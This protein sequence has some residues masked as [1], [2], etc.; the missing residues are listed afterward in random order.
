MEDIVSMNFSGYSVFAD[1]V[2]GRQN[3][4]V[5]DGY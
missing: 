4:F 2:A 1:F 3:L 5:G